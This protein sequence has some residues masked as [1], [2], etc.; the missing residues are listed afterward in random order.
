[1]YK[2]RS[3]GADRNQ[4]GSVSVDAEIRMAPT[5]GPVDQGGNIFNYF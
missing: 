5:A 1:V 3:V 2:V 4:R